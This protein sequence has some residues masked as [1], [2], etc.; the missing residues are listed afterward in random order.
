MSRPS[1]SVSAPSRIHFG[2]FAVGDCADRQFGG[3]GLM[4]QHPRTTV[5]IREADSFSIGGPSQDRIRSIVEKWVA[6]FGPLLAHIS[7][8]PSELEI[9]LEVCEQ[10][11]Q[12][13][14]LGSGTQLALTIATALFRHFN[15]PLPKP[16][17]LAAAMGRG[18][19]SAIGTYGF[20]RGGLLVDRGKASHETVAPL[21]FR[22]DFPGA[23]PVVISLL[24]DQRGL[25]G[26]DEWLA[27]EQLSSVPDQSRQEMIR[28]VSDRILPA[29]M[30]RDYDTFA[31]SVYNFGRQSGLLFQTIQ[32]GSYNGDDVAGLV[33]HIRDFGIAATGQSS[34]GPCVFSICPDLP[35]AEK[36]IDDLDHSYGQ[37][38]ESTLTFADNEGARSK[39]LIVN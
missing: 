5:C 36:L 9:N 13:Q 22:T 11:P 23:W 32:G 24:K 30:A 1:I 20:F 33:A 14:G 12:H 19:R 18:G 37:R 6:R 35:T 28:M 26:T 21:D 3:L 15:L 31:Q 4:I 7:T 17:E 10:T 2:L 38:C 27:F 16:A 25:H 34:W 8:D 29:V 39:V